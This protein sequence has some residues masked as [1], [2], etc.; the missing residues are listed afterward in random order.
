MTRKCSLCAG[1]GHNMTTCTHLRF[2]QEQ[3]SRLYAHKWQKWAEMFALASQGGDD[4]RKYLVISNAIQR[5]NV[6]WLKK[7]LH[8]RVL[9]S[10]LNISP[11]GST[12]QELIDFIAGLYRY[13]VAKK[14]RLYI[15]NVSYEFDKYDWIFRRDYGIV[16]EQK[17]CVD[18]VLFGSCAICY[19][20]YS[21]YS[22]VKTNCDHSF[23][24]KCIVE[25]IKILPENKKLSCAL[26][27]SH[28]THLSCY[29]SEIECNLKSTFL[30]G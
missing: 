27:R 1:E 10:Y 14:N 28:I 20:D 26:C 29:T 30:K 18:N 13:L 23:C 4:W 22:F 3:M 25:T 8:L 15:H 19:E 12:D 6:I 17:T 2:R 21:T 7:P 9:R 11:A 16:V 5:E 24:H